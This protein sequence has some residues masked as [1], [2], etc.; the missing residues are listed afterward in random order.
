MSKKVISYKLENGT[1]PSYVLEGGYFPQYLESLEDPIILGVSV[2]GAILPKEVTE[3]ADE[4]E[5]IEYLNT[6][7]ENHTNYEDN[8]PWSQID[9]AAFLFSKI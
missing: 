5:L 9:A 4:A 1:I 8:T 3:Y 6:Y 7:T 2:D